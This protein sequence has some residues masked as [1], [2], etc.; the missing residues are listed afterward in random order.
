MYIVP[1]STPTEMTTN[2]MPKQVE[3]RMHESHLEPIEARPQSK[4]A[5]ICSS[6]CT[7]LLLTLT[8][9]GVI[10][11]AVF[12]CLLRVAS[13]IHPDIVM[14]IAFPGDI[15]MR[16]LKMLILPLII[17]SLIT[18]L[19]GLD[20]KSSGRL[21]TRAMVYYMTTTVIAAILGVILVLVIHP[22]NPKLKENL[23]QGE[24]NDDVSSLDAFFDLI[25]NLFPENLVQA[26]FQQIQTTT[27]KTEVPFVE[28]VNATVMEGLVA[29]ITRE[30]LIIVTKT[31]QFKSGMNVLGLIGFFIAFGICMGKM[32]ERARLMLEFFNI[33]N[34]IVM[35]LVIC[36]MWYSPFGIAC[37]ICGKII[38]IKDLEVV[39]RQLG[40][41]MV[42]VIIGLIIHGAIFLP[43]I[44][45]AIVRKNPYTFFLGIFQAWITAL[46]TA[47]SAGT[48]PVTFRCLE[49]N[50]GIDKRVTRFVLPVGATI[51]MDGT[52]L[53][54]AVAAIFIA[55]MNGIYL[56]PGQIITVSLTA[57]L[58]SVGAAS[59]PSAG[60]VTMLLI[61]TAVGLPTEDISLLV[62]VDWLLDRFRT[63]VNVVGDSYGAGIVYHLSK[64]ELEELDAQTAKSDDI[65][66]TK[67]QS[68]YDDM[69]NHHEN[70]SN[71]CVNTTPA[72]ATTS[73]TA[74]ATA[75]N[76]VEVV[77]DECKVTSATNGSAAECTLVEE[78]PWKH[79]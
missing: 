64:L 72:I 31:L 20:A 57:T 25:R 37:L 33:L 36:I 49:E 5:K 79:E 1:T 69:K 45:F 60:L 76:T 32:G 38:S 66:M 74:T 34:E 12:G 3:V 17:S 11:G 44:Y 9:L 46:G 50:L 42:T 73:T 61:L 30:P 2:S 4:C 39:G 63:S 56:D 67:T 28:D 78:G 29:N 51:N 40:M 52:A 10:L 22:G 13:P 6:M 8:I 48:L 62:A 77:V 71:Q 70:N 47:S 55:Q 41:Y 53:Y 24:K 16:M 59:I 21:G 58:A 65:E 27:K 75:N 18:G 19:A 68:Y 35:K 43:A 14:V 15:L 23:G 7:N 54:E 26:C